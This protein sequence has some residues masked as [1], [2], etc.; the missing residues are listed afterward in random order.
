MI[1]TRQFARVGKL[2]S[3]SVPPH[4]QFCRWRRAVFASGVATA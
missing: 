1:F 4:E 2:V 3:S